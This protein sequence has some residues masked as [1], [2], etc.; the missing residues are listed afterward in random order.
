MLSHFRLIAGLSAAET[1]VFY[2]Q[3]ANIDRWKPIGNKVIIHVDE[4]G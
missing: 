1:H 2:K 3:N 4:E